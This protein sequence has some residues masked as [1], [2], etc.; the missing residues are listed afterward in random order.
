MKTTKIVIEPGVT[1]SVNIQFMPAGRYQSFEVIYASPHKEEQHE[2]SGV[3][4]P[5][6]IADQLVSPPAAIVLSS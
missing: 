4:P 2:D 1:L 3:L 5:L 6:T